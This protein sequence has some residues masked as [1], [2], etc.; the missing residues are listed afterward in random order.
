MAPTMVSYA[1]TQAVAPADR[2]AYWEEYNR[3]ALVGLTCSPYSEQGLIASERN[4][5][6]DGGRVRLADISGNSH[7]VER[8]PGTCRELP[9]DSVFATLLLAG[10][11]IF[12][13]RGGCVTVRT[14]ELVVYDTRRSYL[15]GFPTEMRQLLVD[16]PRDL[17]EEHCLAGD[18]MAA[19]LLFRGESAVAVGLL[20]TLRSVLSN[21]VAPTG[22]GGAVEQTVLELLRL[23]TTPIVDERAGDA[24]SQRRTEPSMSTQLSVA[25][26]YIERYL[27]EPGLGVARVARV[28]GV[29]TRHLGRIFEPTGFSPGRYIL[30]RRLLS[31]GE[32][33]TDAG[34]SDR[35]VAAVAHE[36]G[37]ASQ[38]HFSRVFRGRFGV[39][40]REMRRS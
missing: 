23:L 10:E 38:A 2:V 11:G 13:H 25:V 1:S 26:R 29:S 35:T 9:K 17:F 31:A 20:G 7:V 27:G 18:E 39:T 14:G 4:L 5:V 28:L 8:T 6:L 37:F 19:P 3:R 40:P 16:I 24:A 21:A 15:F 33:L 32:R 36:L 12:F 34:A 30:E 22:R